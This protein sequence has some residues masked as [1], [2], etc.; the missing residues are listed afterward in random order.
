M[1][2]VTGGVA[3]GAGGAASDVGAAATSASAA[4]GGTGAAAAR[5]IATNLAIPAALGAALP[6]SSGGFGAA[7]LLFSADVSAWA[8]RAGFFGLGTGSYTPGEASFRTL[9]VAAAA[10][11]CDA[12]PRE[13]A[14]VEVEMCQAGAAGQAFELWLPRNTAAADFSYTTLPSFDAPDLD[15]GNGAALPPPSTGWPFACADNYTAALNGS[16][17]AGAGCACVAWNSNGYAKRSFADLEVYA[18]GSVSL[19]VLQPPLG[20]LRLS[21][22]TSLCL[23]VG[24][25]N[26]GALVLAA[27]AD[28]ADGAAIPP[29]QLFGL[30]R[31]IA[32]DGAA[33]GGPLLIGQDQ[34]GPAPVPGSSACVDIWDLSFD[35]DHVVRSGGWNA[36]SNQ[37]FSFPWGVRS[38][39][40]VR[41][42]HMDVCLGACAEL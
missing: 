12:T 35:V 4:A 26:G 37:I 41:A 42:P 28:D 29:A 33:L 36:G 39:M 19:S 31:S 34:K 9:E 20:Q 2:R 14:A 1:L 3:S 40:L 11:T 6:G 13:G 16:A 18:F 27:C 25:E 8:P 10:T 17:P 15:C 7:V 22:N 21:A 38:P 24:T 5:A 30:S 23:A 32:V